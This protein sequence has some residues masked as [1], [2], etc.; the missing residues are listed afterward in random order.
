MERLHLTLRDTFVVLLTLTTGAVDAGSFLGL[1]KV[2]SSVITGNL[3]LLGIAAGTDGSA[4]AVRAGVALVGYSA[5]VMLGAPIAARREDSGST[6][7]RSVTI[8]LA[9]ELAILVA[10]TIG[11]ELAGGRPEGYTQLPLVALLAAA[12]GMQ[13]AAVRQLGQMSSTYMTS[14]LTGVLASLATRSKVDGLPRS[15]GVLAA[16][17]I[18]AIAGGAVVKLAPAWLPVLVL[19][20]LGAV[21]ILSRDEVTRYLHRQLTGRTR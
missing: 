10:F 15:L 6:W 18:G 8:T 12:M 11:W 17:V 3:V 9:V 20:P 1:G 2:F 5:G 13:G 19:V 4:L 21:V 7:P 14:T 16:I